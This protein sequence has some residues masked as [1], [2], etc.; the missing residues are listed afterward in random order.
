MSLSLPKINS[1]LWYD[2]NFVIAGITEPSPGI[3]LNFTTLN[4]QQDVMKCVSGILY[5]TLQLWYGLEN[6]A[7][8]IVENSEIV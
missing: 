4:Q 2:R 1:E 6:D 3:Y 5:R 7:T 8:P